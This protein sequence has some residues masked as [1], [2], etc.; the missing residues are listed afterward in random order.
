MA[1][2]VEEANAITKYVDSDGK[3]T[4]EGLRLL[5]LIVKMLKDHETRLT[6][7]AL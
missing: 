3:L 6:A 2:N 4:V 5:Q 7:G 1:V